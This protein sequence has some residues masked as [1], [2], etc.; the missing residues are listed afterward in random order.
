MPSIARPHANRRLIGRGVRHD[1]PPDP[2][3]GDP[4]LTWSLSGWW[5][6]SSR[7]PRC[8]PRCTTGRSATA[9]RKARVDADGFSCLT[10]RLSVRRQR[11]GRYRHIEHVVAEPVDVLGLVGAQGCD[12][13]R[14]GLT[15]SPKPSAAIPSSARVM[16]IAVWKMGR[17][18]TRWLY[19]DH[20]ALLVAG[21][22]SHEP[23]TPRTPPIA[24]SG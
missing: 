11:R 5:P 8:S 10:L 17:L 7:L 4:R 15:A 24:H 14:S 1:R 19:F 16:P 12:S 13:L 9:D 22:R 20:L 3:F 23:A 6:R 2:G 21:C 18:A